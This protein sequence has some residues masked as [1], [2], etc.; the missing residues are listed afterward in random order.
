MPFVLLFA[1]IIIFF[2]CMFG[3]NNNEKQNKHRVQK[4]IVPLLNALC[5]SYTARSSRL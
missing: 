1:I 5:S 3:D 2:I 4:C